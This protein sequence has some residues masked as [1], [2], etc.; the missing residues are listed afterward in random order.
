[1]DFGIS[2]GGREGEGYVSDLGKGCCLCFV[3]VC[4]VKRGDGESEVG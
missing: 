4:D 3:W 2:V 1:M